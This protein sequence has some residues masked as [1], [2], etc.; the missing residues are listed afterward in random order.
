[1]GSLGTHR[2][3]ARC[4]RF[5]ASVAPT[6]VCYNAAM[7]RQFAAFD[8][9]GTVFRSSLLV[10]LAEELAARGL[11]PPEARGRYQREFHAWFSR[12]GSYEAYIQAVV[13]SFVHHLKGIHYRDFMAAAEEVLARARFQTYRYPRILMKELK[14]KGYYLVAISDSPKA[15][16][17]PFCK[18]WGFDKV[19]GRMYELGPTNRFTGA[20]IDEHLIS[21]KANIVT[22][23]VEKENLTYA[24]SYAMGDTE[25][26]IPMLELVDHPLC[27][28]P[29]RTLCQYARIQGWK[30]VVERKD[31]VYELASDT[32]LIA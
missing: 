31:V 19:Y 6:R 20:L 16:L 9:D 32:R 5:F 24:K 3:C 4:A 7:K 10:E 23:V 14:R 21:N 30:I 28:N 27:F 8:I 17:E 13:A 25:R 22:R 1:M 29:N 12:K 15:V 11:F 26:D 2:G 18:E